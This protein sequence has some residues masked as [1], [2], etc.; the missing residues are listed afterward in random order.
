MP[1]ETYQR[2]PLERTHSLHHRENET[3]EVMIDGLDA[4]EIRRTTQTGVGDGRLPADTSADDL[5]DVLDGFGLRVR[6]SDKSRQ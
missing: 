1:Q 5:T 3:A 4:Q 6:G 2:I